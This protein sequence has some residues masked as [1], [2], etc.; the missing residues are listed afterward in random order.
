VGLKIDIIE[1][2]SFSGK[3]WFLKKEKTVFTADTKPV[4]IFSRLRVCKWT[5]DGFFHLRSKQPIVPK[6]PGEFFEF[7]SNLF[8]KIELNFEHGKFFYPKLLIYFD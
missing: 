8:F 2:R 6:T 3:I 1:Y 4:Y 7:F 5:R